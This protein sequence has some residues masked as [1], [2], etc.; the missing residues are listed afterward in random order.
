MTTDKNNEASALF[1]PA[2]PAPTV[3]EYHR[4]QQTIRSNLERLK[5]ERLAREAANQNQAGS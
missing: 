5:A 4:E 1:K 3:S 2:E